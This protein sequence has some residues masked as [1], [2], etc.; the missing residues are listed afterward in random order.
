MQNPS[1]ILLDSPGLPF[2]EGLKNRIVMAPMTRGFAKD[3]HKCNHEIE[4][5][6]QRRA[7]SGIGLIITEGMVVHPGGNGYNTVPFIHTKSQAESW[8]SAINKVHDYGTKIFAQLWHCGRISHSDFTENY[9]LF[10]ST[11]RPAEGINRQNNKPYGVPTAITVPEIDS[12]IAMFENSAE[13]ALDV[14]FDG[15]EIH[16]GHGY[17]I[18]QF[19][20]AR[21]ND[22]SDSYGGSVEN[23]CRFALELART[24]VSKFGSTK[25]MIRISPSR[26]MSGLYELPDMNQMMSYL[27]SG[28]DEAGIR[29]LDIS[30]ANAD[31]YETSG[32]IIKLFRGEW[33]HVILGGA[34]LSVEQ[35]AQEVL[36]GHLDLV[37]WGRAILANPDFVR[38]INDGLEL[39]A[40]EDSMR[41]KLF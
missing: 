18:D 27:L 7:E 15:V 19:L 40:F 34:S 30:C 17:L 9:P 33:K 11:N 32:K 38:K 8:R 23:R 26:F 39:V 4:Q 13:L 20:D 14:G 12:V 29:L 16:M 6:Y 22:R 37:T 28:F 1:Q 24:L 31:Y 41:S 36:D 2:I 3:A 25:I 21:I 5:Y 10:S 35:A